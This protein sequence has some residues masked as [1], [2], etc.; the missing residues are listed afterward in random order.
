MSAPPSVDTSA[1]SSP[2]GLQNSALARLAELR[3]DLQRLLRRKPTRFERT[4]LDRA[5]L[6]TLRAEAAV[7][8]PKADSN[9]VVR[10]DNVARRVRSLRLCQALP[11]IAVRGLQHERHRS[12]SGALRPLATAC[13]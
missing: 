13:R 12:G 5:A 6:L 8:D 4:L 10:L 2:S 1:N 9:S 3:R 11:A 7:R